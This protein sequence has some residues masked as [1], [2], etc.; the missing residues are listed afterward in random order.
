[1]APSSVAQWF[2][3]VGTISAVI[4]ALFKDFILASYRKPILQISC[5]KDPP[6]T[7]RTPIISASKNSNVVWTG[8]C[9]YVRAQVLNRGKTRAEKVQV[10]A[11]K[12]AKK[13]A[14]QRFADMPAFLP[15]NAKWSNSPPG[16]PSAILDGISPKMAAF[17]DLVGL[18]DPANPYQGRPTGTPAGVTVAELQLEVAPLSGSNLLPPGTYQLT[19]RIA[20]ANVAPIEKTFEFSHTGTWLENDADMRRDGFGL[21]L[22]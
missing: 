10:Y 6:F 11:S 22:T 16:Q 2:G 3:A 4:L 5:S 8:D 14:D 19:L 21:F 12:L 9:Y 17:V 13:G 15:L 20:A 7:S 1:M 18:S